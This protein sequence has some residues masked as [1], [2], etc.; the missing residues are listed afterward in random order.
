M[1]ATRT[2]GLSWYTLIPRSPQYVTYSQAYGYGVYIM[3]LQSTVSPN[4]QF[5]TNTRMNPASYR[6]GQQTKRSPSKRRQHTRPVVKNLSA[7]L[8][9][10]IQPSS[11]LVGTSSSPSQ[12]ICVHVYFPLTVISSNRSLSV[13]PLSLLSP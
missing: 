13:P 6:R 9:K 2:T 8:Q 1:L 10:V 12:L 7:P 5:T 4:Q 11:T 3:E